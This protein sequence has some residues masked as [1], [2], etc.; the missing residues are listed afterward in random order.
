MLFQLLDQPLFVGL[1]ELAVIGFAV[2]D[3]VPFFVL[4][5][6]GVA[7]LFALAVLGIFTLLGTFTFALAGLTV[8]GFAGVAVFPA[9]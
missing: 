8:T 2:D 9:F 5:A 1:Q 7:G 4:A 6:G 3:L